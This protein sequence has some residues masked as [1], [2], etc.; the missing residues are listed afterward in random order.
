MYT[1]HTNTIVAG[2]A[3]NNVSVVTENKYVCVGVGYILIIIYC[4]M[5]NRYKTGVAD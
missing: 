1:K 5:L 3:G 4:D 2:A